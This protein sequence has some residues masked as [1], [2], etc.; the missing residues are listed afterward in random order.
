MERKKLLTFSWLVDSVGGVVT[1]VVMLE[2]EE[3]EKDINCCIVLVS[4]VSIFFYR[5]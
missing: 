3:E 4:F 1:R 5:L 2:V